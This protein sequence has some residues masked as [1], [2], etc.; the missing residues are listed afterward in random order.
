[1]TQ[2]KEKNSVFDKGSEVSTKEKHSLMRNSSEN[3]T[4]NGELLCA[5]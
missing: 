3:E 5:F 1:M 2:K 4:K